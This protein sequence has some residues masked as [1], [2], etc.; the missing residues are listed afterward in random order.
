[1]N[2]LEHMTKKE[3]VNTIESWSVFKEDTLYRDVKGHFI[4]MDKSK[5]LVDV[6]FPNQTKSIFNQFMREGFPHEHTPSYIQEWYDRFLNSPATHNKSPSVNFLFMHDGDCDENGNSTIFFPYC[7]MDFERMALYLKLVE[8]R[9]N[10]LKKDYA[11]R[12]SSYLSKYGTRSA[13]VWNTI[14]YNFILLKEK[15]FS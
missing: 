1:M 10:H 15:I 14:K 9:N 12:H 6:M 2:K 5:H 4:N 11:R 3:L 7:R 8:Q 13:K